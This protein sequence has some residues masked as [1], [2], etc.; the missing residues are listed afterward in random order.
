LTGTIDIS[1]VIPAYLGA[2]TIA[3]CLESVID[4]TAGRRSEI[5][6][7]ESSG[8]A[9][10]AIV[11]E[12]FPHVNLLCSDRRLTAG[13]A[14]NRGAAAARGRLVFFTDQDCVVPRDWIARLERHLADPSVAAA[15]GSVGIRNLSNLSGCAVYFLEFLRHFPSRGTGQRDNNFLIGC[16]SAYRAEVLAAVRFPDQTLGED[17]IFSHDLQR[18]GFSTVYDPAVEVLHHNRRGWREFFNYNRKMGRSAAMY[19]GVLR[20][21]WVAPFFT[22]PVLAYLAPAVVLPSIALD[23][24]RSRWSYF[25]LFLFL[26]PM[27]LLGNLVWAHAFRQQVL[28]SR[29]AEAVASARSS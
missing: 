4:A 21:W 27:C 2:A 7:V 8:D 13:A 17:V 18:A 26:S 1:V 19:H 5:I 28:D 29:R 9:T 6:V 15:G 12:R 10:A 24:L 25:G 16:N 11:R 22:A 14:R 20:R 3:D 23:L